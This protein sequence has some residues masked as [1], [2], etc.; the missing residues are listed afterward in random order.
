MRSHRPS[1]IAGDADDL[2]HDVGMSQRD[3]AKVFGVSQTRIAQIECRALEKLLAAV[4][5]EARN[6]GV[7]ADEWLYGE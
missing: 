4:N 1:T 3:V 5:S 2:P 6:S 7:T